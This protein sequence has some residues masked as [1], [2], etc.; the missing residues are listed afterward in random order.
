MGVPR[1]LRGALSAFTRYGD[2]LSLACFLPC[3]GLIS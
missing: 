1:M 2:A 3:M